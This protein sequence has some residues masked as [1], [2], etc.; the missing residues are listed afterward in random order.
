MNN[1]QPKWNANTRIQQENR[2]Q[3]IKRNRKEKHLKKKEI[4][5]AVVVRNSV[6][7]VLSS[8]V[9]CWFLKYYSKK[10]QRESYLHLCMCVCVLYNTNE[11]N[12]NLIN[13]LS[14]KGRKKKTTTANNNKCSVINLQFAHFKGIEKT[15]THTYTHTNTHKCDKRN[16]GN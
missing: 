10:N 5:T 13:Y 6:I 11:I 8:W 9:N 3:R 4:K 15:Y 1:K 16:K 7:W 2:Q 14:N 12:F